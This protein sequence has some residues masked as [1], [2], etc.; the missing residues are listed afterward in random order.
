MFRTPPTSRKRKPRGAKEELRQDNG[1]VPP[2]VKSEKIE[3]DDQHDAKSAATGKTK[4]TSS[5]LS[6]RRALELEAAQAKATLEMEAVREATRARAETARAKAEA[7]AKIKAIQSD[8][9]DKKLAAEIESLDRQRRSKSSCSVT[10]KSMS[11]DSR[12]H[13]WLDHSIESHHDASLEPLDETHST[14]SHE[15]CKGNRKNDIQ[16]LTEALRDT[17]VAST[18]KNSNDKLLTRLATSKDLPYFHGDSLEW[19]QFKQAFYESTKLCKYTD[20]ENVWRLRKCLR[21]E[22]KDTVSSLLIGVTS[23]DVIIETLELR[24]GRPDTIVNRLIT[25]LKKLPSLPMSY[26]HDIVNF[27]IKVKNYVTAAKAI[28]QNDYLRSPELAS[29]IISKFPN[30][31][32][33]KWTDYIFEQQDNDLPKLEK[34]SEFLY[35]EA[36]KTALAGVSHIQFQ[37]SEK[38]KPDERKTT[39]AVLL[40][41]VSSEA[42]ETPKCR[43]CRVSRHSLPNCPRYKRALRKDRWRFA[44]TQRLCFKCL[45][46]RHREPEMCQGDNC[47]VNECGQPHHRLL[48]WI[49]PKDKLSEEKATDEPKSS[50]E[51]SE[52]VTQTNVDQ[53]SKVLLQI[54]P[55]TIFGPKGSMH[56]HG[57]IDGGSTATLL[58]ADIADH[59]GL[60]GEKRMMRARG[61]WDTELVCEMELIDFTISN[62]SGDKYKLNARKLK[63]LNLPSQHLSNFDFSNYKV[64]EDFDVC[65]CGVQPKLLIG[66]NHHDLIAPEKCIR[67]KQRAPFLTKTALGWCVHGNNSVSESNASDRFA[68]PALN[69]SVDSPRQGGNVVPICHLFS[70]E[71]IKSLS[72]QS[73]DKNVDVDYDAKLYNEVRQSFALESIGICTKPRQSPEDLRAVNILDKT[74]QMFD[75]QWYVGLPWKYDDVVLPESYPQA[76]SRLKMVER[77]MQKNE[78][79][80]SRYRERVQHLFINDFAREVRE[81]DVGFE[82]VWYLPHFGVDNPNKAKLRLVFDAAAKSKGVCINDF[83]LQGPDL[84]QSLLGIM[85]RFRENPVGVIGDIK[86]MFLRI[87]IRKEDMHAF[88]FLWRE[89]TSEPVKEYVM[90]SLIFGANCSPFVA[91]YVNQFK[92]TERF[93]KEFP[94]A[95][96]AIRKNQYMDDYIDSLPDVSSA[97]K[98]VNDILYINQQGGFLMRNWLS[99]SVDVL[100]GTPKET[101]NEK[102]VKFNIEG[103]SERTLGLLWYPAT[104]MLG[105]DLSFKRIPHEVFEKER[106]P[107]KRELL[108]IIMSIYDV[109]GF[110]GPFIIQGKI[111]MQETWKSDIK[112]D[113]PVSDEMFT[114]FRNW[115]E[116]LQTLN[117]ISIPRWYFRV[118]PYSAASEAQTRA[119][120]AALYTL[121]LHLFCD[122]SPSAY[123][124]VA[125][126]RKE[127]SD[128]SV[129]VSF[130]A[131]KSRLAPIKGVTIPRLELQGALLGCRLAD[132]IKSEHRFKVDK[133][134]YWTDSTTVLH[135]IRNEN[136]KYKPFIANR[137]GEICNTSTISEWNYVPSGCNPADLASKKHDHILE[138]DSLWFTGP[139][140]LHQGLDCWPIDPLNKDVIS[141]EILEKIQVVSSEVYETTSSPVPDPQREVLNK[142]EGL[143]LRN[144]QM[145]SFSDEIHCL[146]ENKPLK[147]DSRLRDLTPYLDS[148]GLL[149]VGGRIGA[150]K[151]VLPELLPRRKWT[152][153]GL[154]LKVGDL[155]LVVDP[156]SPRNTWPKGIIE[157]VYPGADGRVRVV[158]VRTG[159]GVIK[160]PAARVASFG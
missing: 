26:H 8:L 46:F 152:Q 101:L 14:I 56:V 64:P 98:M 10:S 28:K 132:T 120:T 90:T 25:Q 149:R 159:A 91:Q 29:I 32:V 59:L 85:L 61:A 96:Q 135:W 113:E 55:L 79:Y 44:R 57:L 124:A 138:N 34:L 2:L 122:A 107:T 31:L 151:E 16:K 116:Q 118:S 150:V 4:G 87:K 117:R 22:A 75:D 54:V 18:S 88:R 112:W 142:A 74:S 100:R 146:Q 12:V 136:K 108:R 153:E 133:T 157:K 80:A 67:G 148:D 92:N 71:D 49:A 89:N 40:S 106:K 48:H 156:S 13:A 109:H 139:L 51:K 11:L 140:F 102:A 103:Q 41:A 42:G 35:E 65:N 114:S 39:H 30:I 130:V 76:L 137:L 53:C 38:R 68:T 15:N 141:D 160:R 21:G 52:T 84:L 47:D 6:R 60:H 111:I 126:W 62:S 70:I 144:A 24:Y 145:Q 121:Q 81:D 83:L 82:R 73:S 50:S 105:F 154:Q 129:Q 78:A 3:S 115:L 86:D 7:A 5:S 58:A 9:I 131:S 93:E 104:D 128:G 36:N 134:F 37:T 155:V 125:Y 158:D 143:L 23:P 43:F 127:N 63:E 77:K 20:T 72:I 19:L 66:Q 17:I 95:V 45:A 147:R 1:E 110:L 99:N 33:C 69:L 119:D 94:D 97:V 27:A 123:A